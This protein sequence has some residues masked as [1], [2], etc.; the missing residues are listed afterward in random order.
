LPAIPG[1][2]V[3]GVV[4]AVGVNVGQFSPSDEV[5]GLLRFT[6][7]EGSGYAEYVS[8]PVSDFALK[9]QDISHVEAA[10]HRCPG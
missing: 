4:E 9:P 3:S 7:M 8:A 6:S 1:T 2:D 5:F 10:A